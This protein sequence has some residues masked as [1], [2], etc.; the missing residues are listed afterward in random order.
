MIRR[1]L[2]ERRSWLALLVFLHLLPVFVAS[3]D[4]TLP[5]LPVLYITLLSSMVSFLFLAARYQRETAF[6][7]QLAAWDPTC[8]PASWKVSGSPFERIVAE[9]MTEQTRHYKQEASDHLLLLEQEKDELLAWIHE[10]KTPLT[11]MKLAMDRLP[12]DSTKAR[13]DY[14]W[15]RIH[16][17][18]DQQLHQRRL[19]FMQNDLFVEDTALAP[20]IA[21]EIKEL[22]SWCM[23]K[24]IG[25][26]V[27]LEVEQVQ[28]DAKW[29]GFILRQILTNA[30]KYSESC[31]IA[32][33]SHEENGHAIVEIT[34]FGRGISPQDLPRIF[35][36][37]FT[38]TTEHQDKAAT[39]MGLYLAQKAAETLLIHIEADSV[40]GNGTTFR[41]LFP[42]ANEWIRL[43]GM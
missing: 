6:F 22:R 26:E 11:A 7:R 35:E 2:V 5:F 10:V 34:D 18:L 8:G 41:L 42:A 30:V 43:T 33:K 32:V 24:G 40:Y 36:R 20:I 28:S 38:S 29:L 31:D 19:P 17:L 4:V 12:D 23:Q 3:V 9:S 27:T 16:H 37:G 21:Q 13:L 25:F 15:L 14:E 39:G 1:Y